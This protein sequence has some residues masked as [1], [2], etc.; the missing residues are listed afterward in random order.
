M[1]RPKVGVGVQ[2]HIVFPVG[3]CRS[4]ELALTNMDGIKMLLFLLMVDV[5]KFCFCIVVSPYHFHAPQSEPNYPNQF[6]KHFRA[7]PQR[8]FQRQHQQ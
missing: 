2:K 1:S 3:Y 4:E 8:R 6:T 7:R 5:D